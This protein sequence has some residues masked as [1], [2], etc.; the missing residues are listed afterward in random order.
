MA[1]A[2][3]NS[4]KKL[5]KKLLFVHHQSVIPKKSKINFIQNERKCIRD[6]NNKTRKCIQ[7][8][9]LP[10]QLSREQHKP[11]KSKRLLKQQYRMVIP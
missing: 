4:A 5:A 11:N 2:L 6:I 9:A 1:K 3:M 7:W 8:H 10:E